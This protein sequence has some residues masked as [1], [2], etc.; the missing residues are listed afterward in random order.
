MFKNILLS[1][2]LPTRRFVCLFALTIVSWCSSRTQAWVN[3]Q[4]D[5]THRTQNCLQL[6]KVHQVSLDPFRAHL[7]Q[8]SG[9]QVLV[10]GR[11][12]G[13]VLASLQEYHPWSPSWRTSTPGESLDFQ[14]EQLCKHLNPSLPP[15]LP[16]KIV[17]QLISKG[18]TKCSHCQQYRGNILD[19]FGRRIATLDSSKHIKSW[20]SLET[21]DFVAGF[22]SSFLFFYYYIINNF[23]RNNECDHILVIGKTNIRVFQPQMMYL[24]T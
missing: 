3:T 7:P 9:L 18:C 16:P 17:W 24:S 1:C 22:L 19:W 2:N 13:Q 8:A 20:L 15:S 11:L 23:Q 4:L 21:F 5:V 14:Q 10:Q 6:R 12:Q